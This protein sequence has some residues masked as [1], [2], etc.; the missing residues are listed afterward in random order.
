MRVQ[1]ATMQVNTDAVKAHTAAM[2]RQNDRSRQHYNLLW[3]REALVTALKNELRDTQM[4]TDELIDCVA[5]RLYP[6]SITVTEPQP[7]FDMA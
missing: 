5:N 6:T 4:T 7:S 2:N 3:E 1:A